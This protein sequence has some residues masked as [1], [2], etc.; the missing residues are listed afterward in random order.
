MGINF[1]T[2]LH[3]T[4]AKLA[5]FLLQGDPGLLSPFKKHCSIDPYQLTFNLACY[6]TY[7][8]TLYL[9]VFLAFV[10]T[11]LSGTLHSFWHLF[12]HFI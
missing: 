7:V 12:G 1:D 6:L 10:V 11:F 5:A 8:L 3:S 2:K 4:R 9:A